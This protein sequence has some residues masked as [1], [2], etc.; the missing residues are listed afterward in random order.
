[1][2]F[3]YYVNGPLLHSKKR[4][5]HFGAVSLPSSRLPKIESNRKVVVCPL[6]ALVAPL[7]TLHN[8]KE[9]REPDLSSFPGSSALSTQAT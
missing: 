9:A 1:M 8:Q 3:G 7:F 2:G 5:R 6:L 4:G